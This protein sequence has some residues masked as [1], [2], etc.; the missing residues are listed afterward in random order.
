MAISIIERVSCSPGAHTGGDRTGHV[1]RGQMFCG[2][3]MTCL[4]A[5]SPTTRAPPAGSN[6]IR[7]VAPPLDG[8][9]GAYRR[10]TAAK[11]YILFVAYSTDS[12]IFGLIDQK[13][14]LCR[15]TAGVR[16]GTRWR[17]S[18][19]AA[20]STPNTGRRSHRSAFSAR[21]GRPRGPFRRGVSR[22]RTRTATARPRLRPVLACARWPVPRRSGPGRAVRSPARLRKAPAA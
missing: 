18:P 16:D 13:G 14:H 19:Q 10:C 20:I 17:R 11:D 6:R 7:M 2:T 22:P 8:G 4:P 15:R 3:E 1:V 5:W 9:G 21:P 12:P